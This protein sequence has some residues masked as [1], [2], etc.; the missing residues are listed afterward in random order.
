MKRNGRSTLDSS[1]PRLFA[2][3]YLDHAATTPPRAE[4]IAAMCASLQGQWGNPSSLHATGIR[5]LE[6]VERARERVAAVMGAQAE[7]IVFTASGTEADNHALVG[8]TIAGE[9]RGDHI[10][11]SV[12]EHH[13][14][15][16]TAEFLERRGVHVTYVPVDA[17]GLVDPDAVRRAITDRTLLV[18]I[19]HANNEVG[20]LQPIAEIGAI[21]KE[22]GVLFHTDAVQTF[23]HVPINVTEMGIDLLSL[24]AHKLY[25]PKGVGALFVR[26]GVKLEPYLHGGGQELG[27]R[28]STENTPG[29]VGLG[30]AARL[31]GLEMKQESAHVSALRDRVI[32]GVLANVS[33]VT[34]TGHPT[35][36]LPNNASFAIRGTEGQALVLEL[37]SEGFAVSS[38]SACSS[39]SYRPSHVLLALGLPPEAARG[40]LRVSVGRDTTPEQV[41][42]FLEVLPSVVAR[43]R[44]ALEVKA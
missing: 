36:R 39:G 26:K 37:D 13:A 1:T 34:L 43:V 12:V 9:G 40:S 18:S 24:A 8:A 35:R 27:R 3:V 14:I 4:V 44:K 17:A 20:T 6:A 31:A 41:E 15:E 29:I 22:R 28:A 7:E 21:C 10:I 2:Q 5:A 33:E 38:G 25:G 19:M 30:E 11:T 32:S 23:G 16:H 42:R